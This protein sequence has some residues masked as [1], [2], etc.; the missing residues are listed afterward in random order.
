M[1]TLFDE[2]EDESLPTTGEEVG[3]AISDALDAVARSNETLATMLAMSIAD[4]IRHIDSR[5]IVVEPSAVQKWTFNVQ[6]DDKGFMTSV[7]A[8]A[9]V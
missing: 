1:T 8:T 2:L 9:G 5:N 6:R 4:A 7:T 3:A